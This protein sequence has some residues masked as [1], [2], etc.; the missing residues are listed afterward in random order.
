MVVRNARCFL[1][2]YL[3]EGFGRSGNDVYTRWEDVYD[4]G[5]LQN[6]TLSAE[7]QRVQSCHV[8]FN[9]LLTAL[10]A[11]TRWRRVLMG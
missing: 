1:L 9:A 8:G 11:G 3:N 7:Q 6:L 5:L 2:R 4:N 10:A